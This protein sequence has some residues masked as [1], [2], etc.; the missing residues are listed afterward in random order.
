MQKITPFLWFDHQAEDAVEFYRSVFRKSNILR[1]TRYGREGPGPEGAVMTIEFRIGDQEFVALN[2]GPVFS[3]S[4]AISFVINCRTQKEIDY[5]WERLS[6]GG[7]QQPC[8]WLKD[9]FGISWQVVPVLLAEMLAD[10]DPEKSGRVM[11]AMLP[12]G[13]LELAVLKKAYRG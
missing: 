7:E 1:I 5:Y 2:G 9:R 6:E 12:M 3:F 13:R 4:Q 10:P 11:K 8:G